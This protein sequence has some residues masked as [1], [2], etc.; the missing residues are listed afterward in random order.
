MRATLY[1]LKEGWVLCGNNM[2]R[3]V[4]AVQVPHY[5]DLNGYCYKILTQLPDLSSLSPDKQKEIGWF[6]VEELAKKECCNFDWGSEIQGF[7]KGFQKALE[8]T[9]DRRFT[10]EDMRKAFDR[11]EWDGS[12]KSNV[13]RNN[14]FKEFIESLS[15]PKSWE[16]EVEEFNGVYKT[17]KIN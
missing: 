9:A 6:D 8:L 17:V 11:G 13:V 4:L 16:V 2:I 5:Q 3:R 15:Q 14:V 1:K 12:D 10:E 7:I